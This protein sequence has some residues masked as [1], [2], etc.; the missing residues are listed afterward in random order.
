MQSIEI[1]RDGI[2]RV[3]LVDHMGTDLTVVNAARVSYGKHKDVFDDGD[4]K[5][6]RYLMKNRHTSP[7]EQVSTT[8]RFICPLFVRSQHHRHRTWCL[9]GDTNITFNHIYTWN[10]KGWHKNKRPWTKDLF[11]LRNLCDKWHGSNKDREMIQRQLIRVFNEDTKT[12]DVSRVGNVLYSGKKELFKITLDD[13]SELKTTKDHKLLTLNGWATLEEMIDLNVSGPDRLKFLSNTALLTCSAQKN[14][15]KNQSWLQHQVGRGLTIQQIANESGGAYITIWKHL[16]QFG[17]KAR[18]ATKQDPEICRISKERA[19]IQRWTTQ[20]GPKVHEKFNYTCQ[21][22]QKYIGPDYKRKLHSHHVK[23]IIDYPDLAYNF[24]NLISL[25]PPCH[26]RWHCREGGEMN[27]AVGPT[28]RAVPR[29]IVK[30]EYIGHE[31]TFDLTIDGNHHN[32]LANGIISHNCYSEISRRYTSDDIAFYYPQQWRRQSKNNKQASEEPFDAP[33]IDQ[34]VRDYC[35]HGYN[36][37][38]E[39]QE[40][41]EVARE[42]ARMILPQNLYTQYY[43]TVNLHNALHF[44]SLRLHP[45]A[46][47]EIQRVAWAMK[48]ILKGLYPEIMNVWE[49]LNGN[50]TP[51]LSP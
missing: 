11:Q 44:L 20:Q 5:L 41:D 17:L 3:D 28:C 40:Q 50:T 49:E 35:L 42:M 25:C 33:H 29:Q 24:D 15:W 47:W 43:G 22:C 7:L 38:L 34:K 27:R 16:K 2:G 31:D 45:H 4:R 32:F 9:G 48:E 51:A 36:L 6:I 1:Y 18:I 37:Y 8:F 12:F 13:G 23:P 30:V 10:N 39:L 19:R 46:Q 26:Y 14:L 21:S